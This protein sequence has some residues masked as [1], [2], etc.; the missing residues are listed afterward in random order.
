MG[1]NQPQDVLFSGEESSV[2]MISRTNVPK[3]S[4]KMAKLY[5][6]AGFLDKA[7]ESLKKNSLDVSFNSNLTYG[8]TDSSNSK[9][10]KKM[11]LSIIKEE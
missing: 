11:S 8:Y 10:I 5:I 9:E 6:K 2:G 7:I 4:I 1:T 3:C